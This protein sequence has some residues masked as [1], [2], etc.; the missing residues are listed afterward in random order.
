M[1]AVE[2]ENLTTATGS[3]GCDIPEPIA[4]AVEELIAQA[5]QLQERVDYL[6][7]TALGTL[8]CYAEARTG[9]AN[10]KIQYDQSNRRV[11]FQY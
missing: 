1:S 3:T 6:R 8:R 5:N 11:E 4:S 2:S 10:A 9:V 7:A